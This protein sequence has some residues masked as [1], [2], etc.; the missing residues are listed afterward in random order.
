MSVVKRK[1]M[2]NLV[3]A[4]EDFTIEE[5]DRIMACMSVEKTPM[6]CSIY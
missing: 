2:R 3:R 6:P 4:S 5:G 1:L